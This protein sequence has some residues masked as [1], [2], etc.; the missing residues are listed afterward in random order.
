MDVPGFFVPFIFLPDLAKD[1]DIGKSDAAFLISIIG[2]ANTF[3]R[4]AAGWVSDQPWADCLIINNCALLIGGIATCLCPFCLN[5][6]L[7]ATYSFVFGC[8]IGGYK[9]Y[10]QLHTYTLQHRP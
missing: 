6:G 4:V 8:C 10:R 3:A 2:I 5:Y 9:G 1:Y 7:L